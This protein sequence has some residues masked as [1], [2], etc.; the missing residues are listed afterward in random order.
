MVKNNYIPLKGDRCLSESSAEL[1]LRFSLG[2]HFQGPLCIQL[3]ATH[4][5]GV[6]VAGFAVGLLA[7]HV[8]LLY[9]HADFC[10][11]EAEFEKVYLLAQLMQQH[12]LLGDLLTLVGHLCPKKFRERISVKIPLPEDIDTLDLLGSLEE[13]LEAL[14]GSLFALL[15]DLED[16]V[17]GKMASLISEFSIV[18][19]PPDT[20]CKSTFKP[21]LIKAVRDLKAIR[22]CLDE[23]LVALYALIDEVQKD[24]KWDHQQLNGSN[25]CDP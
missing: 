10:L 13:D 1:L 6:S 19:A 11:G 14:F 12:D 16:S 25:G 3:A 5:A 21:L 2:E 18:D 20:D 17:V 8:S 22:K 15:S 4:A 23:I 9:D 24:W 7:D